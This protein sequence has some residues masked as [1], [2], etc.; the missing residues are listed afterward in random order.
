MLYIKERG[1]YD[2]DCR[3]WEARYSHEKSVLEQ[4][5]KKVAYAEEEGLTVAVIVRR[6][7]VAQK[8]AM[9]EEYGERMGYEYLP[10]G[11]ASPSESPA[12][13]KTSIED[14]KRTLHQV[15][16]DV[17]DES[18]G[19]VESKDAKGD[20]SSDDEEE[21]D[22]ERVVGCAAESKPEPVGAKED[23]EDSAALDEWADS[24]LGHAEERIFPES[25]EAKK[26]DRKDRGTTFRRTRE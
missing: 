15:Q 1:K 12:E 25:A 20:T 8:I 10:V 7:M 2:D 17:S 3:G 11:R 26:T 16:E 13:P 4:L 18:A 24:F 23:S 6:S 14:A 19:A 9:V 21:Y 5:R 22:E